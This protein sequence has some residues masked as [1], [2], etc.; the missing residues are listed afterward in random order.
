MYDR[1]FVESCI[2]MPDHYKIK[3]GKQKYILREAFKDLIPSKI[4]NRHD[5]KGFYNPG[6][7]WMQQNPDW[8]MQQMQ[9]IVEDNPTIFD[10]KFLTIF[11][12]FARH[13]R[14]SVPEGVFWRVF[15]F[16]QW[17]RRFKVVV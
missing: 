8:W 4:Y 17:M 16:G 11:D 5:K 10:P 2:A 6:E 13:N 1:R 9:A 12:D 3:N 15:F 7:D 14:L